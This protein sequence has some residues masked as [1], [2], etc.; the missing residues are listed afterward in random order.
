M[1]GTLIEEPKTAE[2]L[3]RE[4]RAQ[5]L[6]A[7][8]D[9]EDFDGAVIEDYD[10]FAD[11]EEE[12]KPAVEP[13]PVAS[14]PKQEE[15]EPEVEA[16]VETEVK[17]AKEQAK[18]KRGRPRKEV[19]TPVVKEPKKRG[20]PRK[21]TD[22]KPVVKKP[23]GR[24][25]KAA[26]P[27]KSKEETKKD[28]DIEKIN[29]MISDEESKLSKM[30]MLVSSELDE[31]MSV[32]DEKVSD[33]QM[34]GLIKDVEELQKQAIAMKDTASS[35]QLAKVNERLETLIKEISNLNK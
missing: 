14:E 3:E 29:K 16:P 25:K 33:D 1:N 24:P 21:E 20:R 6:E 30:K 17:P 11:E 18:S 22:D 31:A 7:F 19:T 10:P 34:A 8:G 5:D 4:Q 23:V 35:E 32:S 12:E 13:V 28:L 9:F 27:A 26:A 15:P 2:E